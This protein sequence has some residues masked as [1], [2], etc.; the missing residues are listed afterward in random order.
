[1][2]LRAWIRR[3]PPLLM[4]AF[5]GCSQ[6]S[7]GEETVEDNTP[8]CDSA[9]GIC[10]CFEGQ[11]KPC[12]S[13]PAGTANVGICKVG[14]QDCVHGKWGLCLGEV[15]PKSEDCEG[16]DKDCDGE[17]LPSTLCEC[18]NDETK[19]CYSFD[20]QNL[21]LGDC[22]GGKATCV[23]G[24][25]SACVGEVGPAPEICDLID[26][27]CN[28]KTDDALTDLDKP[29]T[30]PNAMGQCSAGSTGCTPTGLICI[31]NVEPTFEICD[32][33]DN[34]CNGVVDDGAICC[35]DGIQ[36][37]TESDVDC[38][39]I[40]LDKCPVGKKCAVSEDC[41]TSVCMFGIC[42][43]ATCMDSV[44]NG[45]E[46]DVDCGG[47]TCGKCWPGQVCKNSSDCKSSI[48]FNGMCQAGT[49]NDGVV[50]ELETDLDCGG[51]TCPG[52]AAGKKCNVGSD[53]QSGACV[54]SI[55]Q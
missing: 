18:Q 53:C 7:G 5:W 44:Q 34:D 28:G 39:A 27:D 4:L 11:T 8:A 17:T 37:G 23:N 52:C 42:Q 2:L 41:I 46:T 45:A 36:N 16:F 26:N 48:C 10:E 15:L 14:E 40:C 6:V 19:S 31:P 25:W 22:V 20:P 13:G 55:C 35:P 21:G 50:N 30:V 51:P 47:P 1:M 3:G 43:V 38:G 9:D 54:L 49:C 29:C 32:G 33:I 12:Y 24:Q